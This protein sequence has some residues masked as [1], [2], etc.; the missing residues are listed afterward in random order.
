MIGNRIL[1]HSSQYVM[2]QHWFLLRANYLNT[3]GRYVSKL[4][5]NK[6]KKKKKKKNIEK[7]YIESIP[8][9]GPWHVYRRVPCGA[10]RAASSKAETCVR[11]ASPSLGDVYLQDAVT[12]TLPRTV[13]NTD[14]KRRSVKYILLKLFLSPQDGL[15][16]R[17]VFDETICLRPVHTETIMKGF[18]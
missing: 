5:T 16:R 11:P 1:Q 7:I 18:S 3:E 10:R 6:P 15:Y 14:T 17:F 2:S 12:S 8:N 4:K 9:T 13:L